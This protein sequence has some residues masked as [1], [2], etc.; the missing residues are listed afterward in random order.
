MAHIHWYPGHIA[1]AQKQLQEKLNLIDVVIEVI[2]A[3]IPYSSKYKT[4]NELCKN[5]PRI[6]LMNKSDVSDNVQ[7]KLWAEKISQISNCKVIIT[8]LKNKNDINII[9]TSVVQL[10]QDILQKR[11]EKGLLPRPVRTMVIGMPNVGKSSTI[12]RLIKR[13]KTKTGAKAGVTRQQ[14]WVRINDKIELLDTPGIIPSV[15]DDQSQALKLACVNSIGENAY[16]SEYVAVNLIEILKNLYDKEL[17]SYYAF[18]DDEEINIESIAL[19][20]SW[21]MNQGA[22]DIKRTSQIILSTF[23]EGKIGNFTLDRIEEF[24][25]LV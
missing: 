17:R 14:Q 16:D 18:N 8:S 24:N 13:A 23:R 6:I 22:P 20:R 21:I 1:K 15:Q 12:N 4:S 9:T 11:K 2:D 7:N 25:E 10:A 3:R 19:K 5:K